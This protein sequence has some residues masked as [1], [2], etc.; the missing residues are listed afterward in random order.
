VVDAGDQLHICFGRKLAENY[1][2]NLH[3]GYSRQVI[4]YEE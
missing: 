1:I 4:Q 2:K 3:Y